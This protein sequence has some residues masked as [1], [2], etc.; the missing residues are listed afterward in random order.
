VLLVLT[1]PR[2]GPFTWER[3]ATLLATLP[4]A[5]LEVTIYNPTLD[6]DGAGARGLVN[7]IGDALA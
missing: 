5:G 1:I 2:R 4:V 6:P 3:P 7:V